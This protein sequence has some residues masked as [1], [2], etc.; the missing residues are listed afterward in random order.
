M[1]DSSYTL[2]IDGYGSQ[3]IGKRLATQIQSVDDGMDIT[4]TIPGTSTKINLFVEEASVDFERA[5]TL[6]LLSSGKGQIDGSM[7]RYKW[8]LMNT[9]GSQFDDWCTDDCSECT[10]CGAA[11]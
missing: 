8:L 6:H 4:I 1:S 2:Y 11:M 5:G 10:E 3:A 7:R 9:R